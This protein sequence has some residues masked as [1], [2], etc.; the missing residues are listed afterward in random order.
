[1]ATPDDSQDSPSARDL[2]R[3]KWWG[4]RDWTTGDDLVSVGND[5]HLDKGRQADSVVS[6]FGSSTSEGDV[7]DAVVSIF[8]D[9]HVSGT[10]GDS[11]VAVFDNNHVNAK[12][13]GNVVAVINDIELGPETEVNG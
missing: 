1:A 6:V 10:V 2:W 9:N 12:M 8:G 5:S 4:R 11:A 7:R 3:E 13:Y